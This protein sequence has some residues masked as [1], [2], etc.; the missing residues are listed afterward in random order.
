MI[1][2]FEKYNML[3]IPL[4]LQTTSVGLWCSSRD[5]TRGERPI[6]IS[7]TVLKRTFSSTARYNYL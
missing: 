6:A 2:L 7:A 1:V 3:N 5:L 4:K